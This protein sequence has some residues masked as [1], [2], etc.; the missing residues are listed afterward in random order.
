MTKWKDG[1]A[2]G[3]K[4]CT[5]LF[6][7]K[8][9][10]KFTISMELVAASSEVP[11][12]LG[13]EN[14][15]NQCVGISRYVSLIKHCAQSKSLAEGKCIHQQVRT[16]DLEGNL[17]IGSSLLKMYLQCGSLDGA[18]VAFTRMDLTEPESW[19]AAIA[20]FAQEGHYSEAMKVFERMKELGSVAPNS[21]T[22]VTVLNVLKL[23]PLDFKSLAIAREIHTTILA[24]KKEMDA[25]VA[26]SLMSLY[27]RFGCLPEAESIF[28]S[29]GFKD[30]VSWS[31][32]ISAYAHNGRKDLALGFFREMQFEGMKPNQ[33]VFVNVLN[34]LGSPGD[35]LDGERI[36]SLVIQAGMQNKVILA[37]ALITMYGRCGSPA[38]SIRVFRRTNPKDL[39]LWN[40][41]IGAYAHNGEF[42]KSM[43]IFHQLLKAAPNR[44]TFLTLLGGLGTS[45]ENARHAKVVEREI[46]S[47]GLGTD[48]VV[49]TALVSAYGK[50]GH[51]GEARRIFDGI[52]PRNVVSWNSM[53][54]AYAHSHRHELALDLYHRMLHEGVNPTVVTF[55]AALGACSEL[56]DVAE[57]GK[58]IS[59]VTDSGFEL[60]HVLGT[61]VVDM[62][63]K[64]GNLRRARE[65]FD[66]M[67]KKDVVV[68]SA[69]AAA[70]SHHGTDR[71]QLHTALKVFHWMQQEGVRPGSVAFLGVLSACRN[72]G[73]VDQGCAYF[74]SITSDHGL[75]VTSEQLGCVVDLLGRAGWLAEAEALAARMAGGG[76]SCAW[77]MLLGA[78]RDGR[79]VERAKRAAEREREKNDGGEGDSY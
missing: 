36:H 23:L 68:W 19:N 78:C 27:G 7:V 54:S 3:E 62:Y 60:D 50:C 53:I 1:T 34:A 11:L 73:L 24:K 17:S 58:I 22:I 63:G 59:C 12:Q 15:E 79:D 46:T 51:A 32:M 18:R 8:G 65:I 67:K 57:G 4:C 48:A 70:Y 71:S 55:V 41:M 44:V 40:S 21:I 47:R 37:T 29:L 2:R 66:G 35:L 20:A 42:E 13:M 72:A 6:T 30:R 9:L 45:N 74:S 49:A 75:E 14:L 5:S 38:A 69:L 25:C 39:I 56:A 33:I 31:V 26:T 52:E 61:A 16:L 43:R 77:M 28:Q 64:C 76:D 10:I